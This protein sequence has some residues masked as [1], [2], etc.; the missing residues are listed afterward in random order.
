MASLILLSQWCNSQGQHTHAL[1]TVLLDVTSLIREPAAH[2]E[3][4][5]DTHGQDDTW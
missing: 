1:R 4:A 2:E 5:V 3:L